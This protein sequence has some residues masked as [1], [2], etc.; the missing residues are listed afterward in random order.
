[1]AV[2]TKS[3]ALRFNQALPSPDLSQP[4][5]MS[6]KALKLLG[7]GKAP[8]LPAPSQK[9]MKVLG[10]E[11]ALASPRGGE[12]KLIELWEWENRRQR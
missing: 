8:A 12:S 10:D 2:E 1:M 6:P 11:A 7:E 9:A 4:G 5:P 3:S